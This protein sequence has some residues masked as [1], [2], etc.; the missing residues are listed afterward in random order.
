MPRV[1]VYLVAWFATVIAVVALAVRYVPVVNHAVLIVAALSPYL[2]IAASGLAAAL[3]FGYS[4]RL[5]AVALLVAVFA[6]AVQVPQFIGAGRPGADTV[7]V[8]LLI[9]NLKEGSADPDRLTE[10]ARDR[11][12]VILVQEL[13][14]GLAAALNA[15]LGSSFPFRS[16]E[17]EMA[18]NGVGIWSRHPIEGS[19]SD[20]RFQQGLVIAT[21]RVPGVAPAVTVASVH[22]TGP[23]PQPI[24][25]WRREIGALPQALAAMASAAGQRP[26]IVAGDFNAT[27]DMVP[28]RRLLREGFRDAAEQAGAGLVR[29]FPA[30]RSVPPL[31]G[32]D[33]ILVRN[34]AVSDVATVRVPGSDHL[35][36]AATVHVPRQVNTG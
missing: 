5:A 34:S 12:D 26:I 2:A 10:L 15:R 33:H 30:D 17:A 27:V 24:H 32:I 19:D 16:L 9:A 4:P 11:A 1:V 8:R 18:A 3:L 36:V 28:F 23:W 29:T 6:V 25:D 7:A 21:L 22:L 13:T 35:G 14:P 31:I 20:S